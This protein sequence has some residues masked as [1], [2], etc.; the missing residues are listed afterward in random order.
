MPTLAPLEVKYAGNHGGVYGVQGRSDIAVFQVPPN[1][2]I[3]SAVAPT[4]RKLGNSGITYCV[5]DLQDY[6][7]VLKATRATSF[8]IMAKECDLIDCYVGLKIKDINHDTLGVP[9]GSKQSVRNSRELF[10]GKI[11]GATLDEVIAMIPVQE[12]AIDVN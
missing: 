9:K 1:S 6:T 3:P 12:E 11:L 10:N 5:L 7:K 4:M 2:L 8:A